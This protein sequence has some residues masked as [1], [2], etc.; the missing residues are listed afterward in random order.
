MKL[1]PVKHI[2][3][4]AQADTESDTT[5]FSEIKVFSSILLSCG[6]RQQK[7]KTIPFIIYIVK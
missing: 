2:L 1:A 5:P 6:G 3:W 4:A 7:N